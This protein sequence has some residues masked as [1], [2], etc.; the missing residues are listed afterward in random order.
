MADYITTRQAA[1]RK[2]V[3]DRFAGVLNEAS[4]HR[5]QREDIETGTFGLE[6]GWVAFE[7]RQ[8]LAAVNA[9]RAARDLP[10]VPE[11]DV[12]RAERMA[13]GHSDYAR[14][15]AFCCAQI[16]TGAD[17]EDIRG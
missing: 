16:A 12:F 17:A 4:R 3:T 2:A 1:S 14:T 10:S 9:E 11:R 15:F 7:R 13:C 6:P 8:M 5:R